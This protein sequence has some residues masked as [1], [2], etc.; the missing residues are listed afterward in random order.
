MVESETP[1]PAVAFIPPVAFGSGA[2]MI[3]YAN[4]RTNGRYRVDVRGTMFG[5]EVSCTDSGELS[6]LPLPQ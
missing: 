6:I 3:V 2:S 1:E 4:G 5:G